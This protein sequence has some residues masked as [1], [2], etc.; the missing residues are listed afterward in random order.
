MKYLMTLIL[1][2][3]AFGLV[4]FSP[5]QAEA[6]WRRGWGPGVSVRVGPRPAWWGPRVYVGPRVGW[7]RRVGWGPRVYVGPRW[8]WRR[9]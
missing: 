4:S 2:V 8:R 1:A 5:N 6:G 9:W 7:N 3:M